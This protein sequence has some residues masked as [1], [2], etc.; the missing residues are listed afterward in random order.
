MEKVHGSNCSFETN[1]VG[2]ITYLS[3]NG[4]VKGD[5]NFVWRTQPALTMKKYHPV[6]RE[7]FILAREF[8]NPMK[9][10]RLF[11]ANLV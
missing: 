2:D 6:V 3:R 1:A 7:A 4:Q 9:T 11:G 5:E 10:L 8:R